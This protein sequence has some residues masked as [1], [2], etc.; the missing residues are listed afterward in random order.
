MLIL[1]SII[2]HTKALAGFCKQMSTESLPCQG[3][4]CPDLALGNCTRTFVVPVCLEHLIISCALFGS[5]VMYEYKGTCQ[6]KRWWFCWSLSMRSIYYQQ[7]TKLSGVGCP[8]LERAISNIGRM[9][10]GRHLHVSFK[11]CT[12]GRINCVWHTCHIVGLKPYS[13]ILTPG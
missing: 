5:T 1:S 10:A 6:N 8:S 9:A 12:L 7:L 3:K 2:P 11:I 4:E 13:T